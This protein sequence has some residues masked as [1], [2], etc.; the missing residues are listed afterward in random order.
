M[1]AMPRDLSRYKSVWLVTL[2]DLPVKTAR[3]RLLYARFRKDL[4]RLGFT[5]IQ[6]S[7]YAR[8][9]GSERNSERIRKAIRSMLPPEGEVRL[10]MVTDRQYEKMEVFLG[11]KTSEPERAP[12]Q[13]LLL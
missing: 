1:S 3:E 10:L 5:R 13:L 8:F 9:F 4:L 2:F 6:Y 7:V 12:E 11:E